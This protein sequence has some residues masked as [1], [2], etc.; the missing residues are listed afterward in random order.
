MIRNIF[1]PRHIRYDGRK[2]HNSVTNYYLL[3]ILVSIY[4]Q[5]NRPNTDGDFADS[6]RSWDKGLAYST[7]T[8]QDVEPYRLTVKHSTEHALE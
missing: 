3:K 8:L 5:S 2:C 6:V 7:T 4:L 1:C